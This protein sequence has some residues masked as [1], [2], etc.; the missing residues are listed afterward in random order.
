MQRLFHF[1]NKENDILF[2]GVVVFG[3]GDS[4]IT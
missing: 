3:A 2:W 4:R 1:F